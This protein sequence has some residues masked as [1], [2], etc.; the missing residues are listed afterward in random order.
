MNKTVSI[1][2]HLSIGFAGAV[3]EEQI[4]VEIYDDMTPKE[5]EQAKEDAC[6]EWSSN[7]IDLGWSDV[8]ED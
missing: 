7:Y 3:H 2:C 8:T 6:A 4:E 5:I 1:K